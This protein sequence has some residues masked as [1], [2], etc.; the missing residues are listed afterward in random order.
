MCEAVAAHQVQVLVLNHME[1]GASPR[2]PW[3]TFYSVLGYNVRCSGFLGNPICF[4]LPGIPL[5]FWFAEGVVA[6]LLVTSL[7]PREGGM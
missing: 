2:L 7:G 4:Y 6:S 1:L 3:E 5:H